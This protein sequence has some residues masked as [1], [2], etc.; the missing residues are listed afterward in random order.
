MITQEKNH[1]LDPET[2]ECPYPL[3]AEMRMESPVYKDPVSGYYIVTGYEAL[4]KVLLDEEHFRGVAVRG[5]EVV[6]VSRLREAE[7]VERMRCKFADEGWVPGLSLGMYGEP[8]HKQLRSVFEKFLRASKIKEL[9]P[10]VEQTAHRLIDRFIDKGGCEIVSQFAVPLPMIVFGTQMGMREE[11]CWRIKEWTD[12]WVQRFGAIQSEEADMANVAK[13]IE[14]QRFFQPLIEKLRREPDGSLFSDL[15][16]EEVPGWGRTLNN[17]ELHAHLMADTFVGGSETTA[18]AISAGFVHLCRDRET[19]RKLKS[20]PERYLRPF[21]EE[22]LRLE[23]PVLHLARVTQKE[24]ELDGTVIPAGSLILMGFGAANRD[25]R[26]FPDPDVLDLDRGN[27]GSHLTFGSGG[28]HCIGAPLARRE[29]MGAFQAVIERIDDLWLAEG[30][31][32]RHV[33]NVYLR[34]LRKL[35]IEFDAKR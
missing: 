29:L 12:A 16:N 5:T 1:L 8:D 24:F 20:D 7:H 10:F 14:A 15:I 4:R 6:D 21:V 9:A 26:H 22:V 27:T 28:H 19:W 34:I 30:N 13:Q 25:P 11:D 23:S 35:H 3:Y 17:N 32:F 31:D 18:N 2:L 33:P